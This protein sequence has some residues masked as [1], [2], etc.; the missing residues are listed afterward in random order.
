MN[1]LLV[2][3]TR[4]DTFFNDFVLY[5]IDFF[6]RVLKKKKNY[7]IEKKEGCAVINLTEIHWFS[8]RIAFPK[9][10]LTGSSTL[11]LQV[12]VTSIVNSFHDWQRTKA[13][14]TGNLF[15]IYFIYRVEFVNVSFTNLYKE[16]KRTDDNSN[17][18]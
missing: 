5:C 15:N 6:D 7:R 11:K 13:S 12:Y 9:E 1:T 10:S 17:V 16:T 2:S 8:K 4:N 18:D 14:E 3:S